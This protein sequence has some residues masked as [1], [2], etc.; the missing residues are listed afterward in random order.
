ME[1]QVFRQ[2]ISHFASGV[3]VI[4]TREQSTNYGLTASGCDLAHVRAAD[5]AGLYQQEY[6]HTS[7]H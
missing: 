2:V 7:S 4:T 1:S 5:A 6:W 3:T